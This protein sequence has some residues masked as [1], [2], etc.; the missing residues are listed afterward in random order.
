RAIAHTD[1]VLTAGMYRVGCADTFCWVHASLRQLAPPGAGLTWQ[2]RTPPM[3]AGLTDHPWTMSDLLPYQVPLPLWVAP[4]R[5]GRPPQASY[6]P[7]M[8]I[9]A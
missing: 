5:R 6:Q 1:A 2:D 8:A 7:A 9:A 4:K 3:A